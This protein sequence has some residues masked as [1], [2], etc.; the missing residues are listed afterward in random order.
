VEEFE[1][2]EIIEQE[3]LDAA[4]KESYHGEGA[5][6]DLTNSG[7]KNNKP[8]IEGW[9]KV[10]QSWVQP[11]HLVMQLDVSNN[12]LGAAGCKM[13]CEAIKIY[14][15]LLSLDLSSNKILCGELPSWGKPWNPEDYLQDF[16]GL[17]ALAGILKKNRSLVHLSL[18][19]NC[20]ASRQAGTILGSV[21][22]SNKS[23]TSLD[24][25]N[26]RDHHAGLRWVVY[27]FRA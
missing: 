13:L 20:L 2:Q 9:C 7:L 14:K 22:A 24:L 15:P 12:E 21:L 6:L 8:M 19:N 25:S 4:F 27:V 3:A 17:V 23:M 5:A 10:L 26:N 18:C 16:T 11:R 1:A